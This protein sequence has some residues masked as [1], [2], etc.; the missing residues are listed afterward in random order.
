MGEVVDSLKV[1][2]TSFASQAIIFMDMLPYFLGLTIAV[3]NI[4]YLYYKIKN[5]KEQ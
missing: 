2:G 3:M 1:S 5:E 4:I